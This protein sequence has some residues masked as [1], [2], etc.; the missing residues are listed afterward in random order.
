MVTTLYG[1][2][3]DAEIVKKV[4]ATSDNVYGLGYPIGVSAQGGGFFYKQAN[5]ELLKKI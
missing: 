5:M 1:P 3:I 2:T 4:S